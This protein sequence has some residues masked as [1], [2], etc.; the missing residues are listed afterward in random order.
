M[1]RNI[2][3]IKKSDLEY[4]FLSFY[5]AIS[6]I[7]KLLE[8]IW[9]PRPATYIVMLMA[10]AIYII[11]RFKILERKIDVFIAFLL[12]TPIT[13]Y[14][15]IF[16]HADFNSP[17]EMYAMIII[18]Y[19]AYFIVRTSNVD[20]LI[21]ALKTSAYISLAIYLP[22]AFIVE[23]IR[24][25]YI[26]YGYDILLPLSII[27]YYAITE[28]NWYDMIISI[29]GTIMLAIFGSRGA[30]I[31]LA[32]FYIYIIIS[33]NGKKRIR[34]TIWV[35]L[36]VLVVLIAYSNLPSILSWLN[37]FGISSYAL[38][39]IANDQA[40]TSVTRG[41]LYEFIIN[42]LLPGNYL[43]YGPIGNRALMPVIRYQNQPYPHQLFLEI[44]I[45]YGLVLGVIFSI[46]IIYVVTYM[47]I[48]SKEKFRYL[49]GLFCVV[50]LFPLMLSGSFYASGT[51]PYIF[52]IYM[53]YKEESLNQ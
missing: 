1:R 17:N 12:L 28:K 35:L 42:E 15:V 36:V 30:L 11:N 38:S 31:S 19:P 14:A 50:S 45:D 13:L 43:G 51:I 29:V 7:S 46:M 6:P 22:N 27:L 10:L 25:Q 23:N 5:F 18:F 16:R 3:R 9:I 52:A 24:N 20:K 32:L 53:K 41:L 37:R 2:L 49:T 48:K 26:T 33:Q 47:L 21:R 40:F 34:N 44:L 8:K 4:L 39:R